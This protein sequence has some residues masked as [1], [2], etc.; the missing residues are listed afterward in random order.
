MN[1]ELLKKVY[2]DGQLF[3]YRVDFEE[4]YEE[5]FN[6]RDNEESK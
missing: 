3:G 2:E 1:K 5:E 6:T 4:Y